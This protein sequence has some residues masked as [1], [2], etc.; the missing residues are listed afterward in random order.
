MAEKQQEKRIVFFRFIVIN[1][2]VRLAMFWWVAA[3]FCF[4]LILC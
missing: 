2:V 3:D 4:R 1:D